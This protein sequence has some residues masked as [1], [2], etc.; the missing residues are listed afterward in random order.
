MALAATGSAFALRWALGPLVPPNAPFLPSA[1]AVMFVAYQGGLGPGLLSTTL[2]AAL[3]AFLFFPP[4]YAPALRRPEDV[5][6]ILGFLFLGS[7]ISILC[8]RRGPAIARIEEERRRA[9]ESAEAAREV[10]QRLHLLLDGI[11]DYAIAMLDAQGASPPGTPGASTSR[12]GR[13]RV[14]GT[15]FALLFRP[16]IA[17]RETRTYPGA[18]LR[19]GRYEEQGW[20]V[21][22]D[23]AAFRAEVVVAPVFDGSGH[24]RGFSMV[25]A[26][27]TERRV[28]DEA[29]QESRARLSGIIESAMD[30]ILTVDAE[31]RVTAFN[32]AAERMFGYTAAEVIGQPLERLLPERLRRAHAGHVTGFAASGATSRSMES[33]GVLLGRRKD[34]TEFPIEA[35]ISQVAVGGQRLFTAIVRDVTE[36][37]QARAELAAQERKKAAVAELG[38]RAL[39]GSHLQVLLDDAVA[40]VAETLG[41]ELCKVLRLLPGGEEVLLVAGVGWRDGLVGHGRVGTGMDSQAG[42]TLVSQGAVIVEDLG[43]ETRFSGPPLLR[44]HGVVS[45]ISCVIAGPEGKPW[46]VLGA[47]T[48]RRRTFTADD[49]NFLQAVANVLATAIERWRLEEQLEAAFVKQFTIA[50]TL[51]RSL[52]REPGEAQFPGLAVGMQYDAALDEAAIGGDF[53]DAVPLPEGRVAFVVG[54]V[55]GKGLASAAKTAEIRFALRAILHEYPDPGAALARLNNYVCESQKDA[56]AA[57]DDQ[58]GTYVAVSLLVLERDTTAARVAVAGAEPPLLVHAGGATQA[59]EAGG[60]PLGVEAGVGYRRDVC[61]SPRGRTVF[62]L[63]RRPDRGPARAGHGVFRVRRCRRRGARGGGAALAAAD[64]PRRPGRGPR[65]RRHPAR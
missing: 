3:G 25:A 62:P 28:A 21:R 58:A 26:D 32:R 27:I 47:H 2:S 22:K 60:L 11:K 15:H 42:Y 51:Q 4:Y 29:L 5:T 35:T 33:L 10:E 63:H 8:D 13:R 39:A 48:K 38:Q 54:D 46:G 50:E 1:L 40:L 56:A 7:A 53:F 44:E 12:A 20:Q 55:S 57:A 45:G 36:R 37:E 6:Q 41:L 24:L 65:L 59:V 9:Q 16:R 61:R 18:A 19:D 31:Q 43:T 64:G 23:G 49:T 14:V 17:R 30:A 34:G 52:L